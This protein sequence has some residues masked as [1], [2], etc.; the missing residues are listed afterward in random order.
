MKFFVFLTVSSHQHIFSMQIANPLEVFEQLSPTEVK[1]S[2]L[3][4]LSPA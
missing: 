4:F 1:C 3:H 2:Q